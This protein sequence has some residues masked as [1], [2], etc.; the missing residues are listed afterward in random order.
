MG[1]V[2]DPA[3]VA[4]LPHSQLLFT[5]GAGWPHFGNFFN[6]SEPG[7]NL[8]LAPFSSCLL[9]SIISN[10]FCPFP[11]PPSPSLLMPLDSGRG[12][13]PTAAAGI[14][15]TS[16][17]LQLRLWGVTVWGDGLGKTQWQW[18]MDMWL[19]QDWQGPLR[20]LNRE[21]KP[22]HCHYSPHSPAGVG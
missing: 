11:F 1:A 9:P 10:N 20:G 6:V 15:A 2:T 21:G 16:A 19:L 22:A 18:L 17:P 13:P 12:D 8:L 14:P 7:K 5:T 4:A 3:G